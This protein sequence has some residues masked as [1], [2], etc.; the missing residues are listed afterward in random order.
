MKTAIRRCL[1]KDR[2]RRVAD[3]AAVLFGLNEMDTLAAPREQA[4]DGTVRRRSLAARTG[5]PIGAAVAGAALA[6]A[7]LMPL[8]RAPQPA[9][10]RLDIATP[11]S[12][13]ALDD[14][15]SALSPDGRSI[16][17]R[18]VGDSGRPMLWLRALNS[19]TARPLTGTEGTSSLPFWSPDSQ[20]IGFTADQKLKRIDVASG[21]V[22][23]LADAS[24]LGATWG[25]GVILFVTANTSPVSRLPAG[26]RSGSIAPATTLAPGQTGHRFPN[27]LPDGRRFLFFSVGSPDVQGIYLGSLDSSEVTRLVDADRAGVFL[28]PDHILFVREEALYAQRVDLDRRQMVA[29]PV[30]IN[31]SVAINPA[32]FASIGLS[33]ST[34]GAFAYRAAS[35]GIRELSWF[36]P[37]RQGAG[38]VG[39]VVRP[40]QLC[41]CLARRPDRRPDTTSRRQ[42]RYLA[43]G[44]RSSGSSPIHDAAG[45]RRCSRVVSGWIAYRIS[46]ESQDRKPPEQLVRQIARSR[47]EGCPVRVTAEQEHD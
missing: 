41:E 44:R 22:Q 3:V 47:N 38:S 31:A 15:G 32:T 25:D 27:F 36:T 39:V 33:A 30:L 19:E 16:A 6:A 2:R 1:E 28:P 35:E 5:L 14:V 18:A 8:T 21:A 34:T 42:R 46:L 17:F 40:Q 45:H 4:H 7:L 13:G 9:E 10:T 20:S 43:G 24:T 26:G 11:P 12:T 37:E 29:E 23:V